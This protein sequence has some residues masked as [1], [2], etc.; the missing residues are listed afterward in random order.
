MKNWIS[1]RRNKTILLNVLTFGSFSPLMVSVIKQKNRDLQFFVANFLVILVIGA[2]GQNKTA[3]ASN[4]SQTNPGPLSYVG[5]VLLV[6][7]FVTSFIIKP[8][9]IQNTPNSADSSVPSNAGSG[10]R[11]LQQNQ[12]KDLG[13]KNSNR[14]GWWASRKIKKE[15]KFKLKLIDRLTVLTKDVE[16]VVST[17]N[18]VE[19][20]GK[21]E[22]EIMQVT[23][24]TLI[25]PR[26]GISKT[27]TDSTSSGRLFGGVRVGRVLV[28]GSGGSRSHSRSVSYPAPD[29][30]KSVDSGKFIL[31]THGVSFAGALFTKNTDYKKM[32]DFNSDQYS[33]LIAPRTGNK[34][35]I[36]KFPGDHFP[37]IVETILDAVFE[38]ES[39]VID[40]G[41]GPN[42]KSKI[43]FIKEK[44]ANLND[45]F[46]NQ[47]EI[48]EES[49][50]ALNQKLY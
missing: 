49:V 10:T 14:P 17:L 42:S 6:V 22:Y 24:C 44:L 43:K 1:S 27:V 48:N 28:G 36:V 31:S 50:K 12:A 46:V 4:A 7:L 26:K 25:E 39:R 35:W 45:E 30:L 19:S 20:K 38:F 8:K 3:S 16:K 18:F 9:A 15:I 32:L 23:S 47:I 29:I 40:D 13:Q 33:I 21:A 5:F 34:V 2:G 11:Y 37:I 41:D